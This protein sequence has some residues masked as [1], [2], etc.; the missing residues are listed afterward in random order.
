[1]QRIFSLNQ[2][3][4]VL[5]MNPVRLALQD[6]SFVFLLKVRGRSWQNLNIIMAYI[7]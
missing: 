7:L 4:Y 5:N 2:L 3:N 6:F 1:M